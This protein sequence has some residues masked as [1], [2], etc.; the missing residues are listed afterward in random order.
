M[1][2]FLYNILN[3]SSNIVLSIFYMYVLCVGRWA[4]A[5]E[6][7]VQSCGGTCTIDCVHWWNRCCRH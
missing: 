3:K 2:F 4:E 1:Q 7:I 6:R 5:S